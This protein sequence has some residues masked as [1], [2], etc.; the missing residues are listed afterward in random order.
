MFAILILSIIIIIYLKNQLYIDKQELFKYINDFIPFNRQLLK[1]TH[2]NEISNSNFKKI[3]IECLYFIE[4]KNTLFDAITKLKTEEIN[5][6]LNKNIDEILFFEKNIH[7]STNDIKCYI[8][9][10]FNKKLTN[11]KLLIDTKKNIT[12]IPNSSLSLLTKINRGDKLY[13]NKY[14]FLYKN[15]FIMPITKIKFDIEIVCNN[16]S[17]E[18]S[19]NGLFLDLS[20]QNILIASKPAIINDTKIITDNMP[21]TTSNTQATTSNTQATTSNTQAT[22]SNTPVITSNQSIINNDVN[23]DDEYMIL[24]CCELLKYVNPPFNKLLFEIHEKISK[25]TEHFYL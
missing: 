25:L 19:E 21:I 12:D 16:E 3:S 2:H 11:D 15:L 14:P 18:L 22:T 1:F 7:T 13:F 9:T 6:L 17:K 5:K 10:W 20:L 4:N 8:L 24:F 23:D